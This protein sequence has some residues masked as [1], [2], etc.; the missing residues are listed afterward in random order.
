MATVKVKRILNFTSS[1]VTALGTLMVL[2]FVLLTFPVNL[3]PNISTTQE[4]ARH[5]YDEYQQDTLDLCAI[6]LTGIT[7]HLAIYW[8]IFYRQPR[9]TIT[10]F[11][12]GI[13]STPATLFNK[14]LSIYCLVT[15]YAI[16]TSFFVDRSKLFAPVGIFQNSLEFAI[17]LL[18]KDGGRIKTDLILYKS[19]K[20]QKKEA[21]K[22][23]S[24]PRKVSLTVSDISKIGSVTLSSTAS[25]SNSSQLQPLLPKTLEHPKQLWILILSSML[26]LFGDSAVAVFPDLGP[27]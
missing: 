3:V 6:L 8:S 11:Q 13:A 10:Y 4:K 23:N 21:L 15:F 2:I 20:K 5:N 9:N 18:M 26:H 12:N 16:L 27:M 17:V 25:T 1:L 14:L 7:S 24:L 19:S 22:S